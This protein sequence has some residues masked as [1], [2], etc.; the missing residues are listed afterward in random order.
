MPQN[1][2]TEWIIYEI[3]ENE[4]RLN[5]CTHEL[6]MVEMR[7]VAFELGDESTKGN[8]DGWRRGAARRMKM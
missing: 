2:R 7:K 8:W 4:V 6:P 5:T 1:S 3:D